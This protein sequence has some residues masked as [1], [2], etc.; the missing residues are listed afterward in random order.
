[1]DER[2]ITLCSERLCVSVWLPGQ[3]Y[4]GARFDW[5]GIVSQVLLDGRIPFCVPELSGGKPGGTGGTGLC[6]AFQWANETLYDAT[7]VDNYFPIA[8]V[9]LARKTG[10]EPYSFSKAY[11]IKPYPREWEIRKDC[12]TVHTLPLL[13]AGVAIDQVKTLR[14]EENT[15]VIEQKLTNVGEK[16]LE[17]TEYC[18]NFLAPGGGPIA[19]VCKLYLPYPPQLQVRRGEVLASADGC[20]VQSFDSETGTAAFWIKG[21][22]GLSEHWMELKNTVNG[23]GVRIEDRF[24]LDSFYHWCNG[25]E[26]CPETF[27]RFALAPGE[28]TAWSRRY[29]FQGA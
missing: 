9:G 12:M 3:G 22:E 27:Y 2:Q 4:Q 15:L 26:F 29:T 5:S 18:H 6:C 8:G 20:R 16:R 21:Y 24:S 25:G 19:K 13:C 17:G 14:V 10:K 11:K 1:M 28:S 7:P 23:A